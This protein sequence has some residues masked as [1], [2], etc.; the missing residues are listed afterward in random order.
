MRPTSGSA[1]RA[2][3]G[4][5][6][7][8]EIAAGGAPRPELDAA[9]EG[10][11]QAVA[12]VHRLMSAHEPRSDVGRLNLEASRHAVRVHPWTHEVLRTACVLHEA[13]AGVFDIALGPHSPRL[14]PPPRSDIELIAGHC[15]RF[16]HS[17][18]RIDLGGIAKG[19]AVDRAIACLRASGIPQGLVNAGGDLA[20]FGEDATVV[21]I[22]DPRHPGRELCRIELMNAALASSGGRIDPFESSEAMDSEVIDP[23]TRSP[24]CGIRGATVRAPSCMIAD[25]L[26]KVVMLTGE[27]AAAL[28]A[29]YGASALFVSSDGQLR[30]APGWFE[31]VHVA[32]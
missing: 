8:V 24:V 7:F 26:T 18:V 14:A 5:G 30:A 28:L 20:V 23:E 6:T 17:E 1:R 31:G 29:R 22:R 2:R 19:F 16:A 12:E 11:F 9:I 15:V 32:A 4:L 10:A 13:T 25:A 3:P 21:R 27:S